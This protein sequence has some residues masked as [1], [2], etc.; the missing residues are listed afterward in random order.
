[1]MMFVPWPKSPYKKDGDELSV[2][3][4]TAGVLAQRTIY[5]ILKRGSTTGRVL[6]NEEKKEKI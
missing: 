3:P 6:A 5:E 2:V 1:M 4:L